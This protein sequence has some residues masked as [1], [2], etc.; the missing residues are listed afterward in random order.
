MRIILE[1]L[2]KSYGALKALDDVTAEID[3]GQ[4]VAVLGSNGAGKSTLLRCL[5]GVA[6]PDRGCILYDGEPFRRNR[7]DLRRRLMFLPDFP[8]LYAD[9]SLL[10]H[11]SLVHTLYERDS[12]GLEDRVVPLLKDFDLLAISELPLGTL[13]RGQLYKASLSILAAVDPELWLLDEPFASGMDAQGISVFKRLIRGAAQR[14]R[15]ILYSTQL[16]DLAERLSDRVMVIDRGRLHAFDRVEALQ[17][18]GAGST[19]ILEDLF[20]RLRDDAS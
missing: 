4:I 19:G 7:L 20:R 8:P 16:L 1:H 18:D 6:G 10:R 13:S 3:S 9:M 5:G 14:G 17:R 2:S 12:A 15:T 11:L